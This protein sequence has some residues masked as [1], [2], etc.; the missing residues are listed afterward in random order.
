ML[1]LLLEILSIY[2]YL[3]P[4]VVPSLLVC[5][6]CGVGEVRRAALA[7]FQTLAGAT[8]SPYCPLVEKL[9]SAAEELLADPTYLRQVTQYLH[10]SG[11]QIL[12]L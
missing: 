8:S 5:V 1:Q 7:A 6:S 3:L 11:V 12:L 9:L 10:L 2:L 4:T